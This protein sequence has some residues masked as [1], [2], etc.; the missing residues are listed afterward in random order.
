MKGETV[1]FKTREKRRKQRMAAGAV[2][3]SRREHSPETR[4]RWFLTPAREKVACARCATLIEVGGDLVYRHEPR[5]FR[6]LRCATGCADSK[7]Y[8]N[9]LRWEQAQR[10]VA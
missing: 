8:R 4:V 6:C 5:E 7:G 1:S 2:K 10:K 9:S 3:R